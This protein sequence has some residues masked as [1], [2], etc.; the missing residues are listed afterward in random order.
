M[1]IFI[2]LGGFSLKK[3]LNLYFFVKRAMLF[4][5]ASPLKANQLWSIQVFDI[6]GNSSHSPAHWSALAHSTG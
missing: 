3:T 5:L 4:L 2:I 6:K 1:G